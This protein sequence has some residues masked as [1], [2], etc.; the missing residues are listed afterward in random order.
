MATDQQSV[1]GSLDD[2]LPAL[3]AVRGIAIAMVLI[4]HGGLLWDH[5]VIELPWMRQATG[6]GAL[7][8]DLFF[9]LSGFLITGVLLKTEGQP[10]GSRLRSFYAR[11]TLRIFPLYF[12]FLTGVFLLMP[13]FHEQLLANRG[14]AWLWNRQGW[15]WLYLQ[16]W[17]IGSAG[18]PQFRHLD[19]FWSLA[20]E[21]QF[22]LLWPFALLG[23]PRR[24]LPWV[25]VLGFALAA[26]LRVDRMLGVGNW[27]GA[28]VG[29]FCRMDAPLAGCLAAL[30]VRSPT[31]KARLE[32]PAKLGAMVT[33]GA[34]I[35]IAALQER[36]FIYGVV[37][38]TGGL[39]L[40][41]AGFGSIVFLIG[42]TPGRR[43]A[44]W[45][46]LWPLRS[47]GRY[48]YAIYCFHWPVYLV[49]MSS[50]G[51]R[52][53]TPGYAAHFLALIGGAVAATLILAF[54]S[55]HLFEKRILALKHRF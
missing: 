29:T 7:G 8:V 10:L 41:A 26:W 42:A 27:A 3:D 44:R 36:P 48:S 51:Q 5:R 37:G 9:V 21:E 12:A 22:Y 11:R 31:W 33:I 47:L 1:A 54:A 6:I 28:Y 16:N 35:A 50:F 55:W 53:E 43:L 40:A 4:F 32:T 45:L 39:A 25:C 17:L 30:L 2:H 38:V 20:I 34:L 24:H 15:Y 18:F 52:S 13:Y 23:L 19:H 46:D 14:Y 49:V